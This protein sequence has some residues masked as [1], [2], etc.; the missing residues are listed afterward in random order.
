MPR[1]ATPSSPRTKVH[2]RVSGGGDPCEGAIPP[3]CPSSPRKRGS[4]RGRRA[5]PMRWPA[6][7]RC[8][9]N[10]GG[11]RCRGNDEIHC[12]PQTLDTRSAPDNVGA[13]FPYAAP[14]GAPPPRRPA[15]FTARSFDHGRC[16]DPGLLRGIKWF[17]RRL[18]LEHGLISAR[19]PLSPGERRDQRLL[20][21]DLSEREFAEHLGCRSRP[22]TNT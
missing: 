16:P 6:V 2:P 20:L 12:P 18:L 15:D 19:S 9:K 22:P 1:Q 13:H 17:H 8:H 7:G 14:A 11:S 5:P 3:F 10:I 4:L 21:T